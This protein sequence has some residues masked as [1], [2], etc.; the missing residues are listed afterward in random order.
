MLENREKTS[1]EQLGEFGLIAHLNA[2]NETGHGDVIK[3]IGDDA[4]VFGD[5]DGVHV[6]TSDMLIENVHFDLAY[7]PLMHLGY[8]SVVVNLSD[9]CAMNAEPIGVL[10]NMALSSKFTL[11]AVEE[12]YKG[13]YAACK[14]Y[15]IQ[16]MGGDTTSSTRGLCLSITAIGKGEQSAISYRSGAKE[17]DVVCVTGDL[18]AAY[19]GLQLLEREKR[20]FLEHPD[21]QP[22]L[23]GKDYIVGRQLRPEARTDIITSLRELGVKPNAMIDVSDGLAS[24]V[25]HLCEASGLGVTIYEEK[26]PID[27]TA[28]Q[29]AL[30]FNLDPTLCA[31]SGGEDYELLFTLSPAEFEKLKASPDIT[32]IG[33][34]NSDPSRHL[35]TKSNNQH[36]LKAQG[37]DSYNRWKKEMKKD[38][39]EN[40]EESEG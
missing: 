30:D 31:L 29:Q 23:A 10:V 8:K 20:V 11:E 2:F 12:L 39:E 14:K 34:M 28:F 22:D 9:V 3:G 26:I 21:M 19:T 15:G 4:A 27:P 36:E 25:M 13:I 1:L 7:T 38:S 35:I 17:N 33:H 6:V 37:W 32:P 5:G 16:L 18:G 24:D 40:S